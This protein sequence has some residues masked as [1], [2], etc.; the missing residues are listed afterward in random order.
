MAKIRALG[1]AITFNAQTVG[2]ISSI[3]EV[4]P[5][6][7]EL[8]V[9]TLDS[10]GGYREF[11]Q[12]FKDG[13][14]CTLTGFYDSG[15]AGQAAIITGYGTGDIDATVITLP[16]A[17]GTVSFNSYVKSYAIGAAEVDGAVGFSGTL[18][19]TGAVTVA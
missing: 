10:T 12:G 5:D 13:G 6:S 9:T 1:T 7:D 18:R 11:L 15:D 8:D 4:A 16:A 19:I 17:A 2:S 3:S 14:E